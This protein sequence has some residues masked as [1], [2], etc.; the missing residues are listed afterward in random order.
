MNDEAP[1]HTRLCIGIA[2]LMAN[3]ATLFGILFLSARLALP[4][5]LL[6]AGLLGFTVGCL[7]GSAFKA[8]WSIAIGAFAASAIMWTPVVIVTYGFALLGLPLLF[9]YAACVWTGARL[10]RPLTPQRSS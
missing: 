8:P 7:L 6:A 5:A 2:S 9:A 1:W 10:V 4:L 3:L